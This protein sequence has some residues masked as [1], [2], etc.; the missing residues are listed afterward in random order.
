MDAR[1]VAAGKYPDVESIVSVLMESDPVSND[2]W[3]FRT[4]LE[5]ATRQAIDDGVIAVAGTVAGDAMLDTLFNFD[6]NGVGKE[7][8]SAYDI[9]RDVVDYFGIEAAA[10]A[11]CDINP[12]H[13]AYGFINA[14]REA[15]LAAGYPDGTYRPENLVTRAD[16]LEAARDIDYLALIDRV[17]R[18]NAWAK[19]A[20]LILDALSATNRRDG[21]RS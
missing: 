2:P 15:D 4:G 20:E 1:D 17:A 8:D 6:I 7:N 13:W 16:M 18:Q 12:D 3:A 14:I 19:R 21:A 5:L 9:L 11:F 10:T